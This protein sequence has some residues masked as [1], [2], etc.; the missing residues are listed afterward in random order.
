M[1]SA[2]PPYVAPASFACMCELHPRYVTQVSADECMLALE[3]EE[4]EYESIVD[5]G[6]QKLV[7]DQASAQTSAM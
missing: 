3:R 6:S 5:F 1:R 7:V 2:P 4:Y